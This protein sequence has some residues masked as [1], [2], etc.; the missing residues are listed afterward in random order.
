MGEVGGL[1]RFLHTIR[2]GKCLC[3]YCARL[4]MSSSGNIIDFLEAGLKAESLRQKAIASNIANIK[5]PGYRS[6]DVKFETLLS[7]ALESGEKVN[8]SDIEGQVYQPMT[9]PVRANGND[10]NLEVEI[11]KMVKNSLR[12][13]AF[14]RLINKKYQQMDLAMNVK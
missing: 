13:T 11:G 6:L 3:G 14:V 5:T 4:K 9:T 12:H 8:L 7:K 10:V 1:A 2:G